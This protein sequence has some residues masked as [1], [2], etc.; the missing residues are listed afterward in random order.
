MFDWVHGIHWLEAGIV[1]TFGAAA[2]ALLSVGYREGYKDAHKE[3]ARANR[4]ADR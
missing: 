2:W 1:V 4:W 3:A